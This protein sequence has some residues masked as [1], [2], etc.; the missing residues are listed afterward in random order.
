MQT[1]DNTRCAWCGED[2]LEEEA[3]FNTRDL[4]INCVE[5]EL[6]RINEEG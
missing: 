3:D 2:N 4:C 6:E 1:I 5:E